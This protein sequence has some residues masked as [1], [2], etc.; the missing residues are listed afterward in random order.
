MRQGL[1]D[2]RRVEAR[3]RRAADIVA[4]IDASDP[5]LGGFAHHLD[6][7]MLFLVPADRMRRDFLRGELPRHITNRNLVLVESEVHLRFAP[8]F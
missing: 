8:A 2:Q 5:E 1:E 4:D 6:R 3:Q 7:E